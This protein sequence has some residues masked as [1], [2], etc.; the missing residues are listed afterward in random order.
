MSK[1][2]KKLSFW[3]RRRSHFALMAIG[4]L[5]V[6]LL[7]FNDDASMKLNMELQKQINERKEAI[8]ECNDSGEYYRQRREALL[9]GTEELEHIAREE[10]HMQRPTEDVFIIDDGQKRDN[11]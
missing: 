6:L 10:Y 5:L 4:S 1:K 7:F 2:T 9:T 11:R 8:R 3:V